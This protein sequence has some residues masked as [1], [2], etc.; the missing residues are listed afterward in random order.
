MSA[1]EGEFFDLLE[2]S[3]SRWTTLLVEGRTWIDLEISRHAWQTKID[4]THAS[5][6][7]FAMLRS[8]ST[9]DEVAPAPGKVE[10][11]DLENSWNLYVTPD[12]R[13]AKFAVGDG[14]IDVLIKGTTFWSNGNGKSFTNGGRENFGHGQGDGQHL[15]E[16]GDYAP[17][18]QILEIS[19][20]T[21]LERRSLDVVATTIEDTSP[22]H[23][24]NLHGLTI[25]D[26]DYLELSV[27]RERGVVLSASSWYEGAIY[28]I[29]E[30]AK[31][32]FDHVFAP[33]DF[34]IEPQ[35]GDRWASV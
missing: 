30:M 26:A 19:E 12:V 20:G 6:G 3:E 5:G 25:G 10:P 11:A 18:L 21:R 4:R 22:I 1:L 8:N 31:V 28:R 17:L 7:R 2:S 29:V 9:E 27:D 33:E 32:E 13:R 24:R 34:R 14:L 23:R 16:T 15:I 35:F